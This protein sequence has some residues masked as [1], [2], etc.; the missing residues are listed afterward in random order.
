MAYADPPAGYA[1]PM[2]GELEEAAARSG[3]TRLEAAAYSRLGVPL[4]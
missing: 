1:A 2:T 4:A 3:L